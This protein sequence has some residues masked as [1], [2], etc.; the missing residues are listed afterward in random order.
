MPP[1]EVYVCPRGKNRTVST[2]RV[3]RK[4]LEALYTLTLQRAAKKLGLSVTAFKRTCRRLGI[5]KWPRGWVVFQGGQ[6]FKFRDVW[7]TKEPGFDID[8]DDFWL[9]DNCYRQQCYEEY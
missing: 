8:G 2:I 7:V 1:L 4:S 3:T 9:N 5:Y 6:T